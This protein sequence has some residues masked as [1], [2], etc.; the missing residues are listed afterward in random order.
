MDNRKIRLVVADDVKAQVINTETN[1]V[2]RE[3]PFNP[4]SQ[5]LINR[6]A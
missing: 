1:K 3:I 4:S 5:V 2:V 6:V